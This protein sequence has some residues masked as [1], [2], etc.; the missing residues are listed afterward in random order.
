MA[1]KNQANHVP[2]SLSSSK[3][4]KTKRTSPQQL[5]S[6]RK[7]PTSSIGH[8]NPFRQLRQCSHLS[9]A[10][11]MGFSDIFS[12]FYHSI[13][14]TELHAEAPADEEKEDDEG[15]EEEKSDDGDKEEGGEDGGEQ[16]DGGDDE[17]EEE[18]EEEEEEEEP[19]DPKP[20][21]EA[22]KS[23]AV[24]PST[25]HTCKHCKLNA[26][27][28]VSKH[29]LQSPLIEHFPLSP[30]PFYPNKPPSLLTDS[31]QST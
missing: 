17:E 28:T 24:Y 14:F 19:E 11:A 22:G 31:H 21:I 23:M 25:I 15:G 30:H 7:P 4:L 2:P 26:W 12:D 20:K 27:A 1:K 8:R 6:T 9:F 29:E 3:S 10:A 13:G 5:P 18:A 16:E